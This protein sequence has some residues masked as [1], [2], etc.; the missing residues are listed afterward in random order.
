MNKKDK[1]SKSKISIA[2]KI[3][4]I[5][6]GFLVFTIALSLLIPGREKIDQEKIEAK[7]QFLLKEQ[8]ELSKQAKELQQKGKI[9][10]TEEKVQKIE[11]NL[12]RALEFN[13]ILINKGS[14]NQKKELLKRKEILKA[15]L[16]IFKEIEKCMSFYPDNIDTFNNCQKEIEEM[17]NTN[18]PADKQ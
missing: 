15:A 7:I 13:Q 10:E 11:E 16:T 3:S 17:I 1:S 14:E 2:K 18:I 9:K 12:N 8:E 6:F 5:G 4:I